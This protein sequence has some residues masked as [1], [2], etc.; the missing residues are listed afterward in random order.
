MGRKMMR[1]N[2]KSYDIAVI[3]ERK[4]RAIRFKTFDGFIR[5]LIHEDDASDLIEF[6]NQ[7]AE[8]RGYSSQTVHDDDIAAVELYVRILAAQREKF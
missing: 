2:S 4:K 5:F 3:R 7:L 1:I 6:V 8:L